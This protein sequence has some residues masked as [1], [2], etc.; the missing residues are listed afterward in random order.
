MVGRF[1]PPA[2]G[3]DVLTWLDGP[4]TWLTADAGIA[5]VVKFVI[6]YV[7]SLDVVPYLLFCPCDEWINLQQLVLLVPFHNL[8]VLA[9]DSLFAA[10]SANPGVEILECPAERFQLT[11]LATAVTAFYGVIEEVDAFLSHHVLYFAI[12]GEED[13]QADAVGEVCLVYQLIGLWE[14]TSCVEGEDA[15]ALVLT[16]D[17]VCQRLVFN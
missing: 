9:C 10:E 11:Y 4:G 13:F 14:E 17:D 8:H 15:G 16:D 1:P 6:G 12:V 2:A 7:V 5:L 3:A